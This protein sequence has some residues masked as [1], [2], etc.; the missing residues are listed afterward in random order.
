MRAKIGLVGTY[1]EVH[2]HLPLPENTRRTEREKGTLRVST[3]FA[4]LVSQINTMSPEAEYVDAL[5]CSN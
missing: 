1:T 4:N 3:F 5:T 2:L